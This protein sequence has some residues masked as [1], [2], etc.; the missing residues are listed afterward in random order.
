M[1]SIYLKFEYPNFC[2]LSVIWKVGNS[3]F[4]SSPMIVSSPAPKDHVDVPHHMAFGVCHL[5]S[6]V[7]YLITFWSSSE[8]PLVQIRYDT[9]WMVLFQIFFCDLALYPRWLLT[10]WKIR[11]LLKFSSEPSMDGMKTNLMSNTNVVRVW[12]LSKIMTIDLVNYLRWPP[13]LILLF[14]TFWHI[15]SFWYPVYQIF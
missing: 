6:V 7:R 2:C 14:L 5:S 11:N 12:S 8:Q 15:L 3:G 4:A 10:V 9:P 1:N 13:R